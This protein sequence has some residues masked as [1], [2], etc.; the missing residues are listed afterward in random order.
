[1]SVHVYESMCL[2][3]DSRKKNLNYII[4]TVCVYICTCM[5]VSNKIMALR[6]K[7]T[8]TG[9]VAWVNTCASDCWRRKGIS[10]LVTINM[11]PNSA[12]RQ[13]PVKT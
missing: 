3:S 13:A 4:S 5:E 1:M 10:L 7:L 2:Y 11:L 6:R 9:L 8:K 12:T